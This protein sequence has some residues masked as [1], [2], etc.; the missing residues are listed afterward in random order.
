MNLNCRVWGPRP[1]GRLQASNPPRLSRIYF[2][3]RLGCLDSYSISPRHRHRQRLALGPRRKPGI[4]RKMNFDWVSD[5]R[6][7][8]SFS[9]LRCRLLL[10]IRTPPCDQ[11]NPRCTHNRRTSELGTVSSQIR[12]AL[13]SVTYAYL[14][15]PKLLRN[16]ERAAFSN[17]RRRQQS[18]RTPCAHCISLRGGVVSSCLMSGFTCSRWQREPSGPQ[19]ELSLSQERQLPSGPRSPGPPRVPQV[20]L[21]IDGRAMMRAAARARTLVI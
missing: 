13:R 17:R 5:A 1:K 9:R 2:G 16:V 18:L 7:P 4:P 6:S 20:A 3:P 11:S 10:P 14:Y 15:S 8:H 19:A 21:A 12:T